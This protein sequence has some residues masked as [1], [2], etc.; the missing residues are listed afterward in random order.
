MVDEASRIPLIFPNDNFVLSKKVQGLQLY[1]D[2]N[3]RASSISL[4]P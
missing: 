1:V 2:G 4:K 3:L